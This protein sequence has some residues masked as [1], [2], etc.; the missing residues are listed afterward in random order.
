MPGDHESVS[1]VVSA[2]RDDA[3][4]GAG[5]E[6]GIAVENPVRRSATCVFHEHDPRDFEALDGN[7]VEIP[8]LV[9]RKFHHGDTS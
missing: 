6:A 3:D 2:A 5:F 1:S 9:A 8:D 4:P 7:A